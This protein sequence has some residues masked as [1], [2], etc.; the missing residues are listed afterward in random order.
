ME[1]CVPSSKPYLILNTRRERNAVLQCLRT[2]Y[3]EFDQKVEKPKH[4][5]NTRSSHY[6]GVREFVIPSS[7]HVMDERMDDYS[8][9]SAFPI[10]NKSNIV[11]ITS[12][13]PRS[14]KPLY[15]IVG[16]EWFQWCRRSDWKVWMIVVGLACCI[17]LFSN[18]INLIESFCYF[19]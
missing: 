5:W 19:S 4:M 15:N 6:K 2:R 7:E 16:L 8:Y 12:S 10:E 11:L 9:F 1:N 14:L 17:E 13:T 3:L 18:V